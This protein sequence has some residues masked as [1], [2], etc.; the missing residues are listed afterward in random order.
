MLKKAES[1]LS[2]EK[3]REELNATIHQAR[4]LLLKDLGFPSTI[5]DT[6]PRIIDLA[7][8]SFKERMRA[9]S[10]ELLIDEELR[11][12]KFVLRLFGFFCD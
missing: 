12:R 9:K 10:K 11:R 6:D 3:Q 5:K 4:V 2:D 7:N 8:P 1:E